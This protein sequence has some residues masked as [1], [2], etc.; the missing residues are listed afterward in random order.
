M[1]EQLICENLNFPFSLS[2]LQARFCFS[3]NWHQQNRGVYLNEEKTM[4]GETLF[5]LQAERRKPETCIR[6][7]SQYGVECPGLFQKGIHKWPQFQASR[8]CFLP[9]KREQ[10]E[11]INRTQ[12]N[13]KKSFFVLA[14]PFYLCCSLS[15]V[16]T[17]LAAEH[18]AELRNFI[19]RKLLRGTLYSGTGHISSLD[20][21]WAIYM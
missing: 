18:E 19:S 15:V 11:S 16:T 1:I 13:S 7:C 3:W 2:L 20:F 9:I 6:G 12:E 10:S 17:S 4:Y 21:L 14:N 5:C 8:Q